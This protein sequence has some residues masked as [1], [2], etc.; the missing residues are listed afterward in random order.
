MG[1]NPQ[2]PATDTYDLDYKKIFILTEWTEA[3]VKV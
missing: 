3:M 2:N 1:Q